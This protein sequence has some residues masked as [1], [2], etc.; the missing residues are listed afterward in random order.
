MTPD[1]FEKAQQLFLQV[2]KLPEE[3]RVD[4]VQS[5]AESAEIGAEA[6]SLLRYH[7]NETLL[8]ETV[9]SLPRV[10][11]LIAET[12]EVAGGQGPATI[13][14]RD[15]A[16]T[17]EQ[18]EI[19]PAVNVT[20]RFVQST[21]QLLRT[22]LI[23]A[24]FLLSGL[25]VILTIAVALFGNIVEIRLATRCVTVLLLVGCGWYLKRHS[26]LNQNL[27]RV[28]ELLI[29]AIP[30]IELSLIQWFE[31]TELLTDDPEIQIEELRAIVFHRRI[32]LHRH[33]WHVY[34]FKLAPH[35]MRHRVHRVDADGYF[36]PASSHP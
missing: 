31:S 13:R 27:L 11:P 2:I 36:G 23:A 22:R 7:D 15:T 32:D 6:L 10:P 24:T 8:P 26:N 30:L 17:R 28:I 21:N 14:P 18:L 1:I 3:E 12:V 25:M 29:I 4:Y 34:P 19:D 33:L 16:A 9:A 20:E 35:R 5:H